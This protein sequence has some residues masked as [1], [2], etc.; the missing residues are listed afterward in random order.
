MIIRRFQ[1]TD[2]NEISALFREVYAERYVYSDLYVPAMITWRN[3]QHDWYS[4]VA[5]INNKI[6][7]HTALRLENNHATCAELA[8]IVIHPMVHA[9]WYSIQTWQVPIWWS[10]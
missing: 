1:V 8:M 2:A 5:V 3:T 6:I 7:G 4:A 9:S 10:T